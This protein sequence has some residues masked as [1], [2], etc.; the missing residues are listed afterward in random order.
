MNYFLVHSMNGC[1]PDLHSILF[2][3]NK[4]VL[5]VLLPKPLPVEVLEYSLPSSLAVFKNS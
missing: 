1:L 4:H 3:C 2:F 5:G